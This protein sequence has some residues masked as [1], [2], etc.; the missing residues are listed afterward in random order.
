MRRKFKTTNKKKQE[1]TKILINHNYR[2]ILDTTFGIYTK[3]KK[4]ENQIFVIDRM[5]IIN[6]CKLIKLFSITFNKFLF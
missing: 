5:R 6:L 2:F 3:K 4:N 1:I